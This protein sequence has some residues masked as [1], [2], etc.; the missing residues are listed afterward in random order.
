MQLYPGGPGPVTL[1]KWLRQ[2]GPGS[3]TLPAGMA[4]V[5]CGVRPAG[6]R[7]KS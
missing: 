1:C 2:R 5:A 7:H 4:D 6:N 3:V